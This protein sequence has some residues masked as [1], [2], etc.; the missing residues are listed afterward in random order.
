MKLTS[1]LRFRLS[2]MFVSAL[3]ILAVFV[4]SFLLNR[5][6]NQVLDEIDSE[7]YDRFS[8]FRT[9]VHEELL[10]EREDGGLRSEIDTM[11]N[12]LFDY[13]LHSPIEEELY[14]ICDEE[15]ILAIK[16]VSDK[17]NAVDPWEFIESDSDEEIDNVKIKDF[18]S[19][20]RVLNVSLYDDF[21][22]VY[23]VS[24]RDYESRIK[25]LRIYF[26]SAALAIVFIGG[27][28]AWITV[29]RSMKGVLQVSEA[30]DDFGRGNLKRRVNWQGKG[31]EIEHLVERF[32]SMAGQ[33]EA[34]IKE[35][36]EVT[37]NIAHDLRT[38]VTRMRGLAEN[39]L[40]ENDENLAASVIEECERQTTIIEDI[41]NL[42]ESES[43]V[44][45]LK[46]QEV[47]LR[48]VIEDL[49]EI[50]EPLAES[51]GCSLK[52]VL[53][54]KET[55][56]TVDQSR[57]QRVLANLLDNAIKYCGKG[58]IKISLRDE[59]GKVELRVKDSGPGVP[60]E[61]R[62]DIFKRFFRM[63][64]SRNTPGSGLGLSLARSYVRLHGGE[65]VLEDSE[66][67][68]SFLITL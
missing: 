44:L 6:E 39:A 8:G 32:N 25:W 30:A 46:M 52:V 11:E 66:S 43:G 65:L 64:E 29:G 59:S 58:E 47:D 20:F 56:A 2:L 57:I 13:A 18:D 33:M 48:S 23:A 45:E 68:A 37:N 31:S 41:L 3:S 61:N 26:I 15:Q 14:F 22:F 35:M 49:A 21:H 54:E 67:G 1:T 27:A 63:D 34:L 62:D 19:P 55:L 42:A 12:E 38:P 36:S 50:Y 24:L 28:I 51:E 9:F 60:A 16:T 40:K 17:L 4:L 5:V 7:M 10:S 53:P